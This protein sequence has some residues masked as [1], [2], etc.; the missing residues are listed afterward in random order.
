MAKGPAGY[1][2]Y[3]DDPSHVGCPRAKSDMTPCI[4]RD[5]AICIDDPHT[6]RPACVGCGH[7]PVALLRELSEAYVPARRFRQT[8][9]PRYAADRLAKLV[10][11]ATEPAP[12]SAE[13]ST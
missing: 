10:R 4:A 13:R 1:G 11:Q 12:G 3:N 5:G 9:D 8:H 6:D 2:R 7:E